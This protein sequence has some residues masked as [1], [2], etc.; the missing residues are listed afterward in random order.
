MT[1]SLTSIEARQAARYYGRQ[2][3]I[4]IRLPNASHGPAWT[5]MQGGSSRREFAI[6]SFL[7]RWDNDRVIVIHALI[8]AKDWAGIEYGVDYWAKDEWGSYGPQAFLIAR[9][10]A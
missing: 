4:R 1:H 7:E 8:A 5:V 2:P 6:E 9:R 3:Y 10:A